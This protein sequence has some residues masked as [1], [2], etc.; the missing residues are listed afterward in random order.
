MLPKMRRFWNVRAMPTLAASEG[1]SLVMSSPSKH[2]RPW[3]TDCSRLT[4]LNRVVL[5]APFGPMSAVISPSRTSML[6]SFTALRPPNWT[7]TP[8]TRSRTL[9]FAGSAVCASA[10]AMTSASTG[11]SVSASSA[12]AWPR[13]PPS[14]SHPTPAGSFVLQAQERAAERARPSPMKTPTIPIGRNMRRRIMMT[15]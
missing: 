10:A 3:V 5:P 11:G 9:S 6:T 7:V 13:V 8:S 4:T 1:D 14:A 2:T 15:E 12:S